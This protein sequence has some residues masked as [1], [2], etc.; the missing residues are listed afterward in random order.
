[1]N[2]RRAAADDLSRD[3]WRQLSEPEARPFGL[4][5]AELPRLDALGEVLEVG[6]AR[7]GVLVHHRIFDGDP[8][9]RRVP[10]VREQS[11]AFVEFLPH[12]LDGLPPGRGGQ[13]PDTRV[14]QSG[15]GRM[16]D[17]QQVPPVVQ[18][19]TR[20]ADNVPVRS[21]L[22]RQQIAGPRIVAPFQKRVTHRAAIFTR[23]KHPHLGPHLSA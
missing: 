2:P 22:T 4:T 7:L 3:E 8:L 9:N 18:Q 16:G 19:I 14:T 15:A 17:H 10:E 5:V 6:D 23:Y 13:P 20:V 12:L 1:M 11:G 21:I